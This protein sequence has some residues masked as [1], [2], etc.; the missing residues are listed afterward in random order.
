MHA[1]CKITP[2][3]SKTNS[4]V[5]KKGDVTPLITFLVCLIRS[6]AMRGIR[7]KYQVVSTVVSTYYHQI[8]WSDAL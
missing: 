3:L 7:I 5:Y 1:N 4:V 2:L 6:N 8:A